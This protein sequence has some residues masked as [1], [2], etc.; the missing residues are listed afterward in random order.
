V[1]ARID[2]G[3]IRGWFPHHVMTNEHLL[4]AFMLT[5]GL[6]FVPWLHKAAPTFLKLL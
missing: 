4:T 1:D 6:H 2:F 3:G 5:L